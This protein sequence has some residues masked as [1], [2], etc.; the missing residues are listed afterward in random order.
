MSESGA[1][2]DNLDELESGHIYLLKPRNHRECN[3]L[4]NDMVGMFNGKDATKGLISFYAMYVKSRF[5][6]S[7]PVQ[8]V[9][10]SIDDEPGEY[11][12]SA[13]DNCYDIYS[14]RGVEQK[15][16]DKYVDEKLITNK[17]LIIPPLYATELLA[18]QR[19]P[20]LANL[21]QRALSPGSQRFISKRGLGSYKPHVPANHFSFNRSFSNSPKRKSSKSKSKSPKSKSP[22]GSKTQKKK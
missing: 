5:S 17:D 15:I 2:I 6:H 1:K 16:T 3:Y 14:L 20:T 11:L 10:K 19:V 12:I 7:K 18:K 21:A 9:W 13:F 4:L 22:K 8:W